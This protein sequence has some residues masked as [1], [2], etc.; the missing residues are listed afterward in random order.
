[1]QPTCPSCQTPAQANQPVCTRCGFSLEAA[2]RVLGIT[3]QREGPV[4]DP[5]HHLSAA[6]IRRISS[7]TAAIEKKFPQL[8]LAVTFEHPPA[9]AGLGAY[10]FWL[11]NRAGF[12]SSVERGADNHLVLLVVDAASTPPAAACMIGYGLEPFVS[13][14]QLDACL[15]KA[16]RPLEAGHLA[17][18]AIAFF[19]A[20]EPVLMEACAHANNTR[21]KLDD[22]AM[23]DQ[24]E[25]APALELVSSHSTEP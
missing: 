14:E 24:A 18:G 22:P 3:P 19:N 4:A 20:L 9:S 17:K 2:D 6:E 8:R 7:L 12:S 11:F 15:A 1:M 5:H 13:K 10:T 25:A 21:Q 23:T 16:A